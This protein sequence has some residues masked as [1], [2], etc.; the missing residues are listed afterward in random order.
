MSDIKCDVILPVCDQFDFT[1]NCIDSIMTNTLTPYRLIVVN[2]GKSIS[3]KTYLV[4]I[5]KTLGD[6]LVVIEN[7]VN[8]GWVKALNQGIAVSSAPYICFQND[9]T[10]VTKNWL[11]K[12]INI[13]ESDERIGIVNPSWEGRPG[14]TSIDEYGARLENRY[15]GRYIETDWARGFSVVLKKKVVEKIGGIDEVYGLAYFDDV[16]FS[17]RA[18]NAGFL[19]VLALDTYVYHHRNVTFFQVLKGNKWNDLHEKNK[20]IFY[21]RWG[22]PLKIAVIV[23][24]KNCDNKSSLNGIADTAFYLARRQ[25]HIDIWSPCRFVKDNFKHTNIRARSFGLITP[26]LAEAAIY[27]NNRKARQKRYN[28]VFRY[29]KSLGRDYN[30]YVR[31]TVDALSEKTKENISA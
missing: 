2:N 31:S 5:K 19:V 17:V 1:R 3:T 10:V 15:A 9:D 21:K 24:R 6:N 4:E 28:A 26:L 25:H 12:M 7:P 11:G 13:L 22:R 20:L 14:R 30:S 16:D 27:L 8:F 29:G 23:D 18:I